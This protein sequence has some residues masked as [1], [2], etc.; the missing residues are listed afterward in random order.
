MLAPYAEA[1]YLFVRRLN[2]EKI[3]IS[4]LK[5]PQSDWSQD[6]D[7]VPSAKQRMNEVLHSLANL[8]KQ[9]NVWF[10]LYDRT[11]DLQLDSEN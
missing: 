8:K 5:K 2:D 7:E 6:V 1:D 4:T 3:Q 11:H 9:E 10:D